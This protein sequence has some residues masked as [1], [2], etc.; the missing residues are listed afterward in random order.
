MRAMP[1]MH[2]MQLVPIPSACSLPA[3]PPVPEYHP[4]LQA[5]NLNGTWDCIPCST[6]PY[7]SISTQEPHPQ[8]GQDQLARHLPVLMPVPSIGVH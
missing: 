5:G 7:L 1:W 4:N 8:T 3:A 2:A 6:G